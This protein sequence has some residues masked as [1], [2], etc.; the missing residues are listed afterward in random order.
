[1]MSL[2][3]FIEVYAMTYKKQ[4]TVNVYIDG[5]GDENNQ[6]ESHIYPSPPQIFPDLFPFILVRTLGIYPIGNFRYTI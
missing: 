1:M 4:H 3:I 6:H 2:K 5:F